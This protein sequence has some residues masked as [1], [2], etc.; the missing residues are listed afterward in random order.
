MLGEKTSVIHR[1]KF[2]NYPSINRI[3][4]KEFKLEQELLVWVD[5]QLILIPK[6]FKTDLASIP[7]YLH[8]KYNPLDLSLIRPAIL[9]DYMYRNYF[10]YSRKE[11]DDVFYYALKVEGNAIATVYP[12]YIAVRA[13]GWVYYAK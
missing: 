12:I 8:W 3:N 5:D 7:S 13:F 9:H 4:D 2:E 10:T 6:G 1:V 11:A